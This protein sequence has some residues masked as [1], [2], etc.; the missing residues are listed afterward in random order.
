MGDEQLLFQAPD[1]KGHRDIRVPQPACDLTRTTETP[2]E[3]GRMAPGEWRSAWYLGIE[4]ADRP[5]VLAQIALRLA[6]HGVSVARLEQRV[7]NGD[8]DTTGIIT[9]RLTLDDAPDAY[10]MFA[11]KTNG[12]VKV[13]MKPGDA[14]A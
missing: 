6:N 1:R 10:E 4:V 2:F 7:L 8:F 14:A 5:G 9:H 13:V 11:T 3:L 12:C